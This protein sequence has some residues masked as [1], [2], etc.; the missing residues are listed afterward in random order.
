MAKVT[1][2]NG[3][4]LELAPIGFSEEAVEL[5]ELTEEAGVAAQTKQ[6]FNKF[7]KILRLLRTLIKESAIEAGC[8]ADVIDKALR[9][10]KMSDAAGEFMQE[11]RVAL[12]VD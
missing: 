4:E 2:P 8:E 7:G 11:V 3:Q 1:F 9:S 6:P 10:V 12:G 5:I